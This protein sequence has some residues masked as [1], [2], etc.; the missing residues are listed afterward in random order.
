MAASLNGLHNN[1]FLHYFMHWD[2]I[3]EMKKNQEK[4][5]QKK[6]DIYSFIFT[7]KIN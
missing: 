3:E 5:T 7:I 1:N 6:Q 2:L 4:H